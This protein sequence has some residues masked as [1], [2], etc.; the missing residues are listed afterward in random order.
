MIP[1]L[2]MGATLIAFCAIIKGTAIYAIVLDYYKNKYEG[3]A[4]KK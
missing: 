3:G 4:I 1:D 2:L